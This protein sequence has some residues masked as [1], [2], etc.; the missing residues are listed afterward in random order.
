MIAI[1]A[2][3]LVVFSPHAPRAA[4]HGRDFT[5]AGLTPQSA[6][7]RSS[8]TAKEIPTLIWLP[9]ID[10]F[11]MPPCSAASDIDNCCTHFAV[12]M[13]RPG[14]RAPDDGLG[15]RRQLGASARRAA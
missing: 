11:L 5:Q 13:T 9:L 14:L 1:E 10:A 6:A 12:A 15:A 8:I 7:G 4:G 2:I 3:S